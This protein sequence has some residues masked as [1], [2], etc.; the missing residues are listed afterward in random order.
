MKKIPQNLIGERFTKLAI[1]ELY[2]TGNGQVWLCQCD[3]GN[4]TTALTSELNRGKKKSCGC[5]LASH[6]KTVSIG[7]VFGYL[8]VVS[9]DHTGKRGARFWLCQCHCSNQTVVANGSLTTG[10]TKSC[11]CESSNLRGDRH[12]KIWSSF[13]NNKQYDAKQRKIEFKITREEAWEIYKS[14]KE[15]CALSGIPIFFGESYSND[16]TTASMDRIDS[17]KGYSPKNIQWV[18]KRVNQMKND[19]TQDKFLEWCHII[20][21]YNI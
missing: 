3:C 13:W 16:I 4:Y 20:H 8:E 7:D 10:R 12:G 21:K 6:R 9:L 14:Q 15:L 17:S 19:M 5:L 2:S 11:G 1:K 18:H